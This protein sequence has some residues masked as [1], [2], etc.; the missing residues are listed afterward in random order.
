MSTNTKNRYSENELAEFKTLIDEKLEKSHNEL[1]YLEDQIKE[2]NEVSVD[3][4]GGDLSDDSHL[5]SELEMLEKIAE[6]QRQFIRN[7]EKAL[8]RIHNKTYGICS[9]TGELIDKKRLLLVPHTTLSLSAKKEENARK[10]RPSSRKHK[11]LSN[12]SSKVITKIHRTKKVKT[13][14]EDT[15][16]KEEEESELPEGVG[17]GIKDIADYKTP[18]PVY[19]LEN[20][21]NVDEEE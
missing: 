1:A 2:I 15:S 20:G 4:Q 3:S 17:I 14:N 5:H 6:R 7:L 10:G 12:P 16:V 9:L 11:N 8:I 13:G 19:D 21:E 18:L